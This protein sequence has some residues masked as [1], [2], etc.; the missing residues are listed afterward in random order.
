MDHS[1]LLSRVVNHQRATL[2]SSRLT[3]VAHESRAPPLA[4]DDAIQRLYNWVGS[5]VS[6]PVAGVEVFIGG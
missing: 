3:M 5:S 2:N 4:D 6:V 1:R